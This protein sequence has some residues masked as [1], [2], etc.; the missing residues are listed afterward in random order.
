MKRKPFPHQ[1]ENAKELLGLIHTDEHE[2]GYL[3]EPPNYK[4]ALSDPVSDKWIEAMNAEM[5]SMKDNQVCSYVNSSQIE[6]VAEPV[7]DGIPADVNTAKEGVDCEDCDIMSSPEEYSQW[8]SK[9]VYEVGESCDAITDEYL[10]GDLF[11]DNVEVREAITK[12]ANTENIATPEI[13]LTQKEVLTP[14]IVSPYMNRK[15]D[16][17]SKITKTEFVVANSLFAM[18]GDKIFTMDLMR[19]RVNLI[20]FT[21]DL[22]I[23]TLDLM[24]FTM[25]LMRFTLDLIENAFEASFGEFTLYGCRLNLETL[26]PGLFLD[27]EVIDYW[28]AILNYEER[29]RVD[30][31]KSRHFFPT[32]CIFNGNEGGK[33]LEGIDLKKLFSRYLKMHGHARHSVVARVKQTIPS[34]KWKTMQNVRD[35]GLFTIVHMEYFNGGRISEFDFGLAV[36]SQDQ[37]DMLRRLRFKFATKILLHEVNL[38]S[39]KMIKYA[40]EFGEKCASEMMKLVS[41]A[42]KNREEHDRI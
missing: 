35:C 28:G 18:K 33:G 4:A 8:L 41:D 14:S 37:L 9:N 31:S 6:P 26:S 27:S 5:Q 29:F 22:M 34:L 10:Y 30:D 11:G 39:E 42:F 32:G 38:Q 20:R 7:A 23:F 25:D 2:L 21:L 3:N 17:L 15:T 13:L 16:V 24:R 19:F 40:K 12:L 1:M 36:E